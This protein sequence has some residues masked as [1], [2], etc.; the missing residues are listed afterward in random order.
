MNCQDHLF[1]GSDTRDVTRRWFFEQCGVG[2]G[3]AALG[4]LLAAQ[5]GGTESSGTSDDPPSAGPATDRA[6]PL[7]VK[8]PHHAAK[9]KRVIYLFMAGR[10]ATWNCSTTSRSWHGLMANFRRPS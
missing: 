4:Q 1:R 8:S 2:V 5:A 7:A 10:R 3:A 6:N 9:A